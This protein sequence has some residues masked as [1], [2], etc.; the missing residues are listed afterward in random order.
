MKSSSILAL[1]VALVCAG[2]GWATDGGSGEGRARVRLLKTGQGSESGSAIFLGVH[3][4]IE[5]GW[6]IYWKNPGGAG[7]ATDISWRLPHG[8]E[9][10]DL[11]WPLP[12]AF[13]Q[14]GDVPGYGY[15]RSV[16]LAAQLQ[17]T[18]GLTGDAR[19]AASVSWLACK[20]VC[21][22]GSAELES[23]W[24]EVP[25]DPDSSEWNTSLPGLPDPSPPPFTSRV[26]GGLSEEK[27]EVWIQWQTAPGS[28]EWFP[29]PPGEVEVRDIKIQTRG[30]LTRIDAVVR[31]LAESAEPDPNLDSLVVI[32]DDQRERRGWHLA[33]DL[34]KNDR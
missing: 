16:F 34:T 20:D 31:R 3:F 7:L 32:A 26:T 8:V 12:I 14:S 33:V 11:R 30:N 28:V 10:G 13:V 21:V 4:D 22:L 2:S 25:G 19:V 6:H 27:I 17:S 29:D 15:E 9:V 5:P 18:T 24:A 1:I 23:S